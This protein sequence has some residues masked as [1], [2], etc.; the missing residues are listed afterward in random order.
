ME[1]SKRYRN[2][3]W[4]VYFWVVVSDDAHETRK[5]KKWS[6]IFGRIDGDFFA[7]ASQYKQFNGI[8]LPKKVDHGVIAH[9]IHH[10]TRDILQRYGIPVSN[11]TDEVYATL[12]EWCT[13]K[14]Y[15]ALK[16]FKIKPT[17]EPR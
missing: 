16:Q 3:T 10:I 11:D 4:C 8:F 6:N 7:C 5:K 1:K 17:M 9:E 13:N 2:D 15:E 12:C 14:T